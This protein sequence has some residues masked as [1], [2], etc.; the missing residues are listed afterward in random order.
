MMMG[1]PG[2][3]DL[4]HVADALDREAVR[5]RGLAPIVVV[6][7]QLGSSYV[8]TLC[9]DTAARGA[10]ETYVNT[11]VV[12]WIERH[13]HVSRHR[14]GWTVAGYSNGGLCAARFA[15][16]HS[17]RWG[18]ALNISGEEFPGSDRPEKT[19]ADIFHG[20]RAAY[21]NTAV[22][23][24]LGQVSLP[25]TWMVFTVCADDTRHLP[26]ARRGASAAAAAGAH[27]VYLESPSGGHVLPALVAGVDRGFAALYPRLG[28]DLW[29]PPQ[30][31]HRAV[32]AEGPPSGS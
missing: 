2:S 21:E 12:S 8:D 4:T 27:S 13:L 29:H 5:H 19:L 32:P 24:L 25:D 23:Q 30:D 31:A 17:Q 15:A 11:D 6:A 1:S 18:N 14:S 16:R 26:G 7:D 28:L 20:D 3:P 22:P 9:M 10:V